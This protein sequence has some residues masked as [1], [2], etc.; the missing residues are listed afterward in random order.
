[1]ALG[2]LQLVVI[3]FDTL[4]LDGSLLHELAAVRSPGCI[5]LIDFLAVQK[6][7]EGAI[8]SAD[9][10]DLPNEMTNL[11][12]AAI[13]ALIGQWVASAEDIGMGT[14]E[15][16]RGVLGISP[17]NILTI[18]DRIPVGGAALLVL[19]EHTWLIPLR[20]AIRA[21]GGVFIA[22]DFLGTESLIGIGAELAALDDRTA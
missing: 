12:G 21:Q 11:A 16:G 14:I 13:S 5:R 22:N 18:A 2:P 20:D 6:D 15:A 9:V 3:G 10:N 7:N 19:V 1:M 17:E 4:A 8:W